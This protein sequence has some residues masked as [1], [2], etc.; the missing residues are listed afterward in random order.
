MEQYIGEI[1]A[2]AFNYAPEDDGWALCNGQLL[3]IAQNTALFS[4][5]GTTFGGN[6]VTNFALPDLR[7]RVP[8]H[9]G[10]GPGLS[11]REMGESAGE[12]QVTL[13]L[14][15]IPP[16]QHEVVPVATSGEGSLNDPTGGMIPAN[17]GSPI[18]ATPDTANGKMAPASCGVTGGGQG[19]DNLQPYLVVNYIIAVQGIFP[20]RPQA[21]K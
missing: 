18:Y 21:G 19:H 17:S 5:L 8:M 20:P 15:Q 6:G 13:Y 1:R 12:E 14:T 4:L 2:V 9:F 16:H 3:S 7:G 10:Q 11:N